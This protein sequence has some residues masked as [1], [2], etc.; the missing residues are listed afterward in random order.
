MHNRFPFV[1]H[2]SYL[3]GPSTGFITRMSMIGLSP[4]CAA[5]AHT[6]THTPSLP[7]LPHFYGA[8]HEAVSVQQQVEVC[9]L[10]SSATLELDVHLD[11]QGS[12]ANSLNR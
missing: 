10:W 6:L 11:I 1:L 4:Q 3:T 9:D 8:G 2:T 7:H 5:P 12:M